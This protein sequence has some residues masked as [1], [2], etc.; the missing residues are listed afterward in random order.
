MP[1]LVRL[2]VGNDQRPLLPA[3]VLAGGALL[4]LA[5]T[6]GDVVVAPQQLPGRRP[7]GADRC[8]SSP[9]PA[10]EASAMNAARDA[11]LSTHALTVSIGG[12]RVCRR[13]NSID[14]G[15]RLAI[16]GRNG[17]GRSTLLSVSLPGCATEYRR[18]AA[19][20]EQ[21]RRARPARGMAR[22]AAAAPSRR[23]RLDRARNRAHRP[24]PAARP[25]GLKRDDGRITHG[26]QGGRPRRA[27]KP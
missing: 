9:L 1:H 3:S 7:D 27:G 4:T 18:S 6:L 2:V 5:D 15:E 24:P 10:G 19:G 21:L 12:Q 8:R 26:A 17:A 23:L 22:L 20:G 25:L 13:W 11:L 16:L 14:A